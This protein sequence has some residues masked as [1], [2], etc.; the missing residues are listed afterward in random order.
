[1]KKLLVQLGDRSYPIYIG[2]ELLSRAEL[3]SQHIKS[4][5]VLVVTNDTIAPLYLDAVLKNL[6][7]YTVETVILP[8]G[9]QYKT[10]DFVTKIFDKLLARTSSRS[11]STPLQRSLSG[12]ERAVSPRALARPCKL[13]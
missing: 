2:S 9:E 10:L 7:D 3:F 4:R 6:R 1:M 12:W 8:D 5:Q 11:G 13:Y